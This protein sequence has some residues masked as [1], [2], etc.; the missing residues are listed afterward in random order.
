MKRLI[1]VALVAILA[2]PGL[3]SAAPAQAADPPAPVVMS[4]GLKPDG[5]VVPLSTAAKAKASKLAA[6]CTWY[7][8]DKC[9]WMNDG[10]T[11]FNYR[12][13]CFQNNVGTYWDYLAAQAGFESGSSTVTFFNHGPSTGTPTSCAA[14]P[15]WRPEQI[16]TYGTYGTNDGLCAH[17]AWTVDLFNYYKTATVAMNVSTSRPAY[18]ADT[19]QH[20]NNNVSRAIGHIL[21]LSLFNS[22]TNLTASIMNTYFPAYNFPGTDDRNALYWLYYYSTPN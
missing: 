6:S 14:S 3:L 15:G 10:Y 18:C 20:R 21:G 17:Y 19:V 12:N 11:H 1:A 8:D 16:L 2:L 22:S 7:P 9:Y 5:S 13:I 4:Y